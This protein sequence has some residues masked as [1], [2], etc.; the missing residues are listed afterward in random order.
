M[1]EVLNLANFNFV[2]VWDPTLNLRGAY[3]TI[4]VTLT[5]GSG[6]SLNAGLIAILVDQETGTRTILK[7]GHNSLSFSVGA[8]GSLGNRFLIEYADNTLNFVENNL[9]NSISVYPNPVENN[10]F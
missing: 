8:S 10:S 4:E 1:K 2:Y 3:A 9:I 5:Y 6:G 7:T